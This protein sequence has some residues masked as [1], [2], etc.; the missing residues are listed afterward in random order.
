MRIITI[1][2][3]VLTP[4]LYSGQVKFSQ[5]Q[6]IYDMNSDEFENFVLGQEFSFYEYLN[7]L[8]LQGVRYSKGEG[9]NAKF[10]GLLEVYYT[11]GRAVIFQ[12][13]NSAEF[14][15]MKEEMKRFNYKLEKSE[16]WSNAIHKAKKDT[17]TGSSFTVVVITISPDKELERNYPTYQIS[18]YK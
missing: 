7:D 6:S 3:L 15:S 10:I 13:S 1:F 4:L 17:Y 12:T 9:I 14:L 18:L 8:K 5:L 16:D 11:F 2:L